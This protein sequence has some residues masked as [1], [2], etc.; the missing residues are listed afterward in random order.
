MTTTIIL[1]DIAKSALGVVVAQKLDLS[2]KLDF[3]DSLI[4]KH[5]SNG[6]LYFL[7]SDAMNYATG[8]GSKL[9]NGNMYGVVDDSLFLGALSAG[10]EL[11]KADQM[12]Y[13]TLSNVTRDR[14][15]INIL[16]DSAIV[17]TGR[18]RD[19]RFQHR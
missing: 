6:V 5:A 15:T 9:L 2:Q 1:Q 14:N 17:S 13:D 7:I 19:R 11:T 8:N 10:S 4:M 16:V 18:S 3:G 12:L